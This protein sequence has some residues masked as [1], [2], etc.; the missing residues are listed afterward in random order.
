[1][2]MAKTTAAPILVL[3]IR[4]EMIVLICVSSFQCHRC[5]P[6]IGIGTPGLEVLPL[7]IDLKSIFMHES[8]LC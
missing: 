4:G 1:M 8:G 3:L 7:F 2:K 5:S 6:Q